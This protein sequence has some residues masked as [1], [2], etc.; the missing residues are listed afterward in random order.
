MNDKGAEGIVYS[1]GKLYPEWQTQQDGYRLEWGETGFVLFAMLNGISQI[2][3]TQFSAEKSLSVRYTFIEDVCYFTFRFGD[4]PWAD[5]PFS[6]AIYRD[7]E[8]RLFPKIRKNEG[9]ALTVMLIDSGTGELCGLRLLGLGHDFSVKWQEWAAKA[10]KAPLDFDEYNR[11]VDEA[12]KN[13]AS[14]DLA[15]KGLDEG[16]EYVF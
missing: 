12:Y 2:E 3:R 8:K 1:V 16:N 10:A 7:A 9:L 15:A 14:V 6:P 11:R 13:Y 4:M 5:C